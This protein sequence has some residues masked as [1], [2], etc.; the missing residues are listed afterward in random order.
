[1]RRAVVETVEKSLVI[2][3]QNLNPHTVY[4][5]IHRQRGFVWFWHFLSVLRVVRQVR[6]ECPSAQ[7][8]SK[9]FSCC[10]PACE[11][12]LSNHLLNPFKSRQ[13][14]LKALFIV[15]KGCFTILFMISSFQGSTC[16]RLCFSEL[17][18]VVKMRSSSLPLS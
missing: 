7:E 17:Q 11:P 10:K 6:P 18:R 4:H 15:P 14:W 12:H 16:N 3:S 5:A 13:P 2:S 9:P 8:C 1:M